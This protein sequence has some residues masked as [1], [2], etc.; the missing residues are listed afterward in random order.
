[1]PTIFCFQQKYQPINS[2]D[3]PQ[4]ME[5]AKKRTFGFFK[6][7]FDLYVSQKRHKRNTLLDSAAFLRHC[8]TMT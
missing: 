5:G 7:F 3:P 6:A 1:M 2:S 8:K 4:R